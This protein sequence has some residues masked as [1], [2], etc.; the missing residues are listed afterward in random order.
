MD[1]FQRMLARLRETFGGCPLA[2]S[3]QQSRDRQLRLLYRDPSFPSFFGQEE[4]APIPTPLFSKSERYHWQENEDTCCLRLFFAEDGQAIVF[5]KKPAVLPPRPT[6]DQLETL[7]LLFKLYVAEETIRT[8]EEEWGK[9]LQGIRSITATLDVDSI[10]HG[11]IGNAL[12]VIPAADAGLL[13]LYE[14]AIDR[15]VPK[16]TVGFHDRVLHEFKLRVGESIAGKV[17]QD[18]QPRLY[19]SHPETAQGMIDISAENYHSL[20]DAKGLTGLNG[21]LCVPISIEEKRIGVLVL[22]Q[23]HQEK[24]FSEYD[25]AILQGFADQT[26]IALQ[27]AQLYAKAK[28]AYE[29][30]SSISKQ[31]QAKHDALVKRN[32]IHE[33]IKQ[34][35]LQ[36]KGTSAIVKALGRMT[37]KQVLFADWLEQ[38]YDPA[39]SPSLFSWDEL[40]MLVA[41]RRHPV[42]IHLQSS[43]SDAKQHCCLFPLRNG[44]VLLGC[45]IILTPEGNLSDLE[46]VTIEQGSAVLLLD[47]VKKQSLSS[48]LYKRSHDNFQELIASKGGELKERAQALGLDAQAE[49]LVVHAYLTRC[50]D[51]AKLEANIHRLV[52]RWKW[53]FGDNQ[54]LTYGFHNHVTSLLQPSR[55]LSVAEI[56]ERLRAFCDEW[57]RGG[58]ANLAIGAGGNYTGLEQIG[59]SFEEAKKAAHYLMNRSRSGI[60]RYRD[61]GVNR[62]ML[63]QSQEDIEAFLG[64]IFAPFW[65]G[66]EK[67]SELEQ[68]LLTYMNCSQSPR[69]AARELHIHVN[70]LYQRLRKIEELLQIDLRHPEDLLKVQLACH[71]RRSEP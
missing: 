5:V 10:I 51:L 8:K 64:D 13:H 59:K 66:Q 17:F 9:F 43:R 38:R 60:V 48:V 61:L 27:N 56:M 47:L 12:A 26:A 3:L 7:W 28:A 1:T 24:V 16:A 29:N 62:L 49:Y 20:N 33:S 71:L 40:S 21:L 18:G 34:L 54:V 35:S 22:H 46:R 68:T 63:N 41:E 11:I 57:S 70:T 55:R 67:Y 37:G 30:M 65:E 69:Q 58:E 14:P 23:F 25:L 31:L 19:R 50:P 42:S 53:E 52:N 39:N 36:N 44:S 32:R 6:E 4:P 45:L 15:L 2:I